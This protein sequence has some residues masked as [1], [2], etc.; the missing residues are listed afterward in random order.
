MLLAA[1]LP[2]S[3]PSFLAVAENQPGNQNRMSVRIHLE[4]IAPAVQKFISTTAQLAGH[5]HSVSTFNDLALGV[6]ALQFS[7]NAPYAG[8]CT[9]RNLN[10]GNIRSWREIPAVPAAAF[11]EF[12]LS[13]LKPGECTRVFH[14]SGTTAQKPGRHFHSEASLGLYEMSVLQ[15]SRPRLFDIEKPTARNGAGWPLLILTPSLQD[16]PHSSLVYMFETIR[17]DVG[18]EKTAFVGQPTPDGSWTLDVP[19]AM[20]T[21][22]QLANGKNPVAVLGT[23][24]SFVHLLDS[25]DERPCRFRLPAGSRVLETGGYKGRSRTVPKPELHALISSRLGGSEFQIIPEYGMSELSSQAYEVAFE[26]NGSSSDCP[27]G[28]RRFEFP[29]WARVQIVSPETGKEVRDGETGLIRVFDLA[30]V[31]SVMAIQTED[32]GVRYGTG[33]ELVGRASMAE[34]RGCSLMAAAA[35]APP[36][37]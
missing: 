8:F 4:Q 31:Y 17:R 36:T 37:I 29:P 21:L 23:A 20:D 10:P 13:C 9:A 27:M 5:F 11:K 35:Q 3:Y 18:A 25:L 22:E 34:P 30:N 15:W 2:S 33:F 14:S 28:S 7:R 32:L 16:A 1:S 12:E 26:S 24:F 19:R 6:F